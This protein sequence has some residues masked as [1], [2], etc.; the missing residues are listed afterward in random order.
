MEDEQVGQSD[1]MN[2]MEASV[3]STNKWREQLIGKKNVEADGCFFK[4]AGVEDRK[5]RHCRRFKRFRSIQ[6]VSGGCRRFHEVQAHHCVV[7]VVDGICC[8]H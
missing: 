2:W 8:L 6:V 4:T 1:W 7:P 3:I 5:L